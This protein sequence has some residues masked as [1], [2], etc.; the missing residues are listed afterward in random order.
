MKGRRSHS[1][2]VIAAMIAQDHDR[3]R[4]ALVRVSVTNR[5]KLVYEKHDFP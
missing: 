2:A 5:K 3:C 4:E 1:K